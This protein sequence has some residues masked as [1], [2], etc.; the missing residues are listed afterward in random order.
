[1]LPEFCVGKCV[2][3]RDCGAKRKAILF[4]EGFIELLDDL[5]ALIKLNCLIYVRGEIAFDG[6]DD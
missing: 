3:F 5:P 6:F 2:S 1:M 4:V